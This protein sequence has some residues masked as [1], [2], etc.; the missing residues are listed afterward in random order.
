MGVWT[1]GVDFDT[2][3]VYACAVHPHHPPV[4]A[5]ASLVSKLASGNAASLAAVP[6]AMASIRDQLATGIGVEGRIPADAWFERGRGMSRKGDWILGAVC[7]ALMC[8]WPRVG[9]GAPRLLET[10]DW[11]KQ[12]GA[13]GNSAKAI[14]N[15]ATA[16]HLRHAWPLALVPTDHNQL[17]AYA[18]AT[19]GA[20]R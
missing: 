5:Q 10:A 2:K 20:L 8:T 16:L 3:A 18:I 12:M 11:K 15:A 19:T 6:T 4:W 17:D 14:A 1:V 7:G 13:P 9:T